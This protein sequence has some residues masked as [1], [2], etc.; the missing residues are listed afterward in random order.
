MATFQYRAVKRDGSA[1]TGQFQAPNKQDAIAQI[2]RSVGAP[3]EVVQIATPVARCR[4]RVSTK[5]RASA[6]AM[7]GELAVLLNAGLPLD[8]AL[9]LAIG[10]IEHPEAA[11][12][13]AELLR[14]TREGMPLSRAM[15]LEPGLFSPEAAA[16]AEAGEANGQ[17][18]DALTRLS[19]MLEQAAELRRLISTS[20]IY[21]VALLVIAIGVILMMLLFVVPQ[22]ETLMDNSRADLP[23]ASVAVVGISKFVRSYGLWL[24][25]AL[26]PLVVAANKGLRRP[27]ARAALDRVV[28]RLPQIGELVR[29]IETAR[30]AHTLGALL[31]GNVPLPTALALAQR[32]IANSVM[33]SALAEVAVGVRQGG[34]LTAPIAAAKIFPPLATGFLRT[35][36]ETSQLG[37]MLTRLA[38]VLDRDVRTRLQRLIAVL[39]P[40]I[41][42]ILGATVAAI[43]ASIMSAILGFN[44]LAVAQ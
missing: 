9:A 29:R 35:G 17:L 1:T 37:M 16:M 31:E 36:E 7:I 11:A 33:A 4:K 38:V 18:G 21:P 41:T 22:F 44:D 2:R 34:G 32:T 3:L 5:D 24:L 20:M 10:N 14:S 12:R 15:A 13:L 19:A 28:L 25:G 40:A 42:V 26:T 30:F 6:N 43:I 23:A 8:R 39:T 27:A